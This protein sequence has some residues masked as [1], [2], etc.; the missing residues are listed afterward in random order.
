MGRAKKEG[1]VV[2]CTLHMDS[3]GPDGECLLIAAFG[4]KWNSTLSLAILLLRIFSVSSLEYKEV[5]LLSS[6]GPL[7]N[8]LA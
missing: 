7:N 4:L 1:V 8:F 6:A 2:L 5:L 3:G